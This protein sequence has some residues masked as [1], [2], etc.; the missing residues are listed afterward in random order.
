M[1]Q[2]LPI[3][4]VTSGL[5]FPN[6]HTQGSPND[7][8]QNSDCNQVF[9]PSLHLSL[10]PPAYIK[11]IHDTKISFPLAFDPSKVGCDL[12]YTAP[13][14]VLSPAGVHALRTVI[15]NNEKFAGSNNR[16]PKSLRG[17]GYRSKFI[18]DF[19][20]NKQVLNHIS[21]CTGKCLHPHDM[22]MNV[23]QINFG[24]IGGGRADI[25]HIDSVPY[26]MVLLL[27]DATDMVNLKFSFFI[28]EIEIATSL[29]IVVVVCVCVCVCVL[30]DFFSFSFCC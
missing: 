22:G 13:F 24:K 26:V 21:Q 28:V 15:A 9:N 3:H 1:E 19:T 4:H 18:L 7:I 5:S 14:R 8:P 6:L 29:T 17:I 20:Y 2:Q 10:E 23:A 30:T 16:Q 27:S 12:A 25:W 11:T